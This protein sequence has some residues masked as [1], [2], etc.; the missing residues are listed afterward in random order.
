[1][2]L[3]AVSANAGEEMP[4]LIAAARRH[5]Y[6]EEWFDAVRE[7]DALSRRKRQR[8]LDELSEALRGAQIFTLMVNDEGAHGG[9]KLM[10][11]SA[12][13]S[14]IPINARVERSTRRP[15]YAEAWLED[16]TS[17][18]VD[19]RAALYVLWLLD[20]PTK[21]AN[22]KRCPRGGCNALF[23]ADAD[24][25]KFKYCERHRPL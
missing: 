9:P 18:P 15:A 8:V 4:R 3:S 22:L 14:H 23:W 25:R 2:T 12:A 21:R 7:W 17:L 6:I 1:M 11:E 10:R 5:P 20:A 13:D 19:R 16:P 24:T